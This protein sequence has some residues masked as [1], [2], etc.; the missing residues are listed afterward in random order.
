M[1]QRILKIRL[2]ISIFQ[3][4]EL[5]N[6]RILDGLLRG[7]CIIGPRDCPFSSIARLFLDISVRV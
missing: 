3:V 5:K 6:V 4:E 2:R 7:Y 1:N